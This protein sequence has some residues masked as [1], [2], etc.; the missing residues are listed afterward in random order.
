MRTPH[1]YWEFFSDDFND[2]DF[3]KN[4]TWT[5]NN[6]DD[7]PGWVDVTNGFLQFLRTGAGGNGGSVGIEIETNITL[8][9][10]TTVSFDGNAVYR[11]VGDGCGWTCNEFPVNVQLYLEDAAGQ[12]FRVRYALNYGNAIDN[13]TKDNFKQICRSVPQ[14]EW[15]RNISYTVRDAWPNAVKIKKIYL[16]GSGWNFEGYID[17]IDISE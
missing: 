2:D 11:S 17:N 12:E 5:E 10:S 15:V 13:Q 3:T 16:F 9:D 1:P 4:P 6:R 7:Y 14:N 8:T